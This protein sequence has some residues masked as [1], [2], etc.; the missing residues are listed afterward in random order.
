MKRPPKETIARA[1]LIAY[2]ILLVLSGLLLSVAGGYVEWYAVIAFALLPPIVIG[3]QRQRM[4][5]CLC[6]V[7]T[8]ILIMRDH[9]AGMERYQ[10]RIKARPEKHQSDLNAIQDE[11]Q[12]EP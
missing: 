2:V 9:R 11:P 10:M 1:C 8:L 5:V 7:I 4:V 12:K 3:S 6:L